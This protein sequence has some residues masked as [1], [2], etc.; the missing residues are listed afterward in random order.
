MNGSPVN[1]GPTEVILV[2]YQ[3]SVALAVAQPTTTEHWVNTFAPGASLAER[4]AGGYYDRYVTWKVKK[5]LA[6]LDGA[7][8]QQLLSVF[9]DKNCEVLAFL[10]LPGAVDHSE[11]P[12]PKAKRRG[13][14]KNNNG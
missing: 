10:E 13:K 11:T 9:R 4:A 12:T 6:V 5:V 8:A 2:R 14:V 3:K 7:M 1:G